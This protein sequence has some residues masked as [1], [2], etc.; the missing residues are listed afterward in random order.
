M[1]EI[2]IL[3]GFLEKTAPKNI[4]E[5]WD[6]VGLLLSGSGD[7]QKVLICLDIS[8]AV[9]EEAIEKGADMIISHHPLIFKGIKRVTNENPLGSKLISLI[10]NNISVYAMHTNFDLA[11]GGLN[12]ILFDKLLLSKKENLMKENESGYALG[13][14]G[15]FS[16]SVTLGEL[17]QFIKGQINL[18][19]V[20]FT[21]DRNKK[22]NKAA[23]AT[24]SCSNYNMFAECLAKNCDV[25][26]TSDI[27]HHEALDALEMGL[28]L[29]D[30]THYGTEFIMVAELAKRLKN[31]SNDNDLGLVVMESEKNQPI[32]DYI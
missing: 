12:D 6:N 15:V 13:R 30:A 16:E 28:C 11:F 3:E 29:I 10:K 8:V 17:V 5:E 21:G 7:I 2:K 14:V 32:F 1:M 4:A 19:A 20:K 24:G 9:V 31:F 23:I 27:K 22:I 18:K 26:I 25:Y